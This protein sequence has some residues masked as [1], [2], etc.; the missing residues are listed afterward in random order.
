MSS[1]RKVDPEGRACSADKGRLHYWRIEEDDQLAKQS[2]GLD[3]GQVIRWKSWYRWTAICLLA[4]IYLAVAIALQRQQDASSDPDAGLIPITVPELLR[5]LRDIVI[6]PPRRDRAHRLHW[7]AW[8]IGWVKVA[9]QQ[10]RAPSHSGAATAAC[11]CPAEPL[12]ADPHP[13]TAGPKL[14]GCHGATGQKPDRGVLVLT[15]PLAKRAS[16]HA[17]QGNLH[18]T[19][20]PLGTVATRAESAGR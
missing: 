2:T 16:G 5:L 12:M 17:E 1:A 7:S 8:R 3:A 20:L 11:V 18:A 10:T 19:C 14:Q 9:V 13:W 4:C 15:Q 6:S